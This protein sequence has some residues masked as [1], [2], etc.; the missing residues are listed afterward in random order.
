MPTQINQITNGTKVATVF[1]N[2][3]DTFL[4]EF[5]DGA[6][7]FL[8]AGHFST[9]ALADAKAQEMVDAEAYTGEMLVGDVVVAEPTPEAA[10]EPAPEAAPEPAPEPAPEV[11]HI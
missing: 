8:S 9:S 2:D 10:P 3:D 4:V 7:L 5:T 1:Q 6:E 11:N